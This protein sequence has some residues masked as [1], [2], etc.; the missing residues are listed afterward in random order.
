[1]AGDVEIHLQAVP[2]IGI[3]FCQGHTF[4]LMLY[5]YNEP[6]DYLSLRGVTGTD[7]YKYMKWR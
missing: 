1:M 7:T 2:H 6:A 5:L 3:L 4:Y